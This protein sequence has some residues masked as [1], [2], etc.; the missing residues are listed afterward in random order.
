MSGTLYYRLEYNTPGGP[1]DDAVYVHLR[2]D[3]NGYYRSMI[4]KEEYEKGGNYDAFANAL[5]SVQGVTD[6]SVTAFRVWY[7][8]SPVY[9]WTE[10]NTPILEFLAFWFGLT[11]FEPLQGSASIDGVRTFRLDSESNRRNRSF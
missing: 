5:F 3:P 11:N 6:I 7:M 4:G 8:K 1:S 9:T 10:V 2:A